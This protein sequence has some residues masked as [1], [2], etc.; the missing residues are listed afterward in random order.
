MADQETS[1]QTT[2][3]TTE[4]GQTTTEQGDQQTTTQQTTTTD[5]TQQTQ[6]TADDFAFV[7]EKYR[8]IGA[9]GKLDLKASSQKMSEGYANAVKRI[10]SGDLPPENPDAYAVNV[11]EEFKDIPLDEGL[12]KSFRDRAHK[13]GLTQKQFDFVMGE[14]FNLVPSLLNAKAKFNADEANA[15]LSK[16]WGD[17]AAVKA[18]KAAAEKAVG[19][20]PPE[21]QEQIRDQYATDPVFWQFAAHFGKE[22]GEDKPVIPPGGS[23]TPTDVQ[24]LMASEAYRNPKHPDHASTSEKV[25]QHFEKTAGTARVF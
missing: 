15:T 24:A 19:L 22:A 13:E 3:T 17:E 4:G 18:N 11:P 21:L 23:S 20:M 6:Q 10:G 5:T 14:Y 9:D 7:P 2:Q 12:S 16:V 1:T 25:R 8:V